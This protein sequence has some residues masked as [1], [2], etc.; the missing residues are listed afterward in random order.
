[1]PI[2]YWRSNVCSSVLSVDHVVKGLRER[3]FKTRAAGRLDGLGVCVDI[4]QQRLSIL[5]MRDVGGRAAITQRPAR[6]FRGLV[7]AVGPLQGRQIGEIAI[8]VIVL[9]DRQHALGEVPRSEEHT[10]ELQ[11]LM[12]SSSAVF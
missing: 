12:R 8:A 3:R 7:V 9:I 10:S 5:R 1:M 6:V 11:S 2:T 4:E